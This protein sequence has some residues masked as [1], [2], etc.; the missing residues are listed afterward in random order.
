MQ[1]R[2]LPSYNLRKSLLLNHSKELWQLFVCSRADSAIKLLEISAGYNIWNWRCRT[3]L[4]WDMGQLRTQGSSRDCPLPVSSSPGL[5][6]ISW[7][8]ILSSHWSTHDTCSAGEHGKLTA[9]DKQH[10]RR[11]QAESGGGDEG[12]IMGKHDERRCPGRRVYYGPLCLSHLSKPGM[13]I[14][15]VCDN[16]V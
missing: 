1:K 5:W 12:N 8:V 6:L 7:T 15:V 11:C 14:N 13:F 10:V 9:Q 2:S 3:F 4:S 16:R